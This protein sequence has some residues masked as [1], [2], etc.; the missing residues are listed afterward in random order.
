MLA[1]ILAILTFVLGSVL[2][3]SIIFYIFNYPISSIP[4]HQL[5]FFF[6]ILVS[7]L[8]ASMVYG[9]GSKERASNVAKILDDSL[10]L[11]IKEDDIWK[12]L[13]MVEQMPPF[14]VNKYVSLNINALEE[15]EDKIEDYKSRL[16]DKDL[17]EIKRVIEMPIPE[18]QD[19]LDKLYLETK[20]EHFKILA[21]PKAA[22]LI[23]LNLQ[24]LKR[25]FV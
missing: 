1:I 2:L 17:L 20:L 12:V 5:Y 22:P 15:F 21:D 8:F 24:E 14:V 7:A 16:S 23:E 13:R 25:V 11:E 3:V 19:L 18:L 10:G 9:R 4:E 6:A